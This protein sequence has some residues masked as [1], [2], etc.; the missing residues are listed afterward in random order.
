MGRRGRV[1]PTCPAEALAKAEAVLNPEAETDLT[2]DYA[3]YTDI[4]GYEYQCPEVL[5]RKDSYAHPR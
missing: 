1:P 4:I 5:P 2:A 3:D